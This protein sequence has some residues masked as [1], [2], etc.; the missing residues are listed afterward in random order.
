MVAADGIDS[1]IRRALAPEAVGGR[2]RLRRLAG[3]DP[4]VPRAPAARRARG[5][6][7]DARRRLPLRRPSRSASAAR[8]AGAASTGSPPRPARPG[9][10]RRPPSSRCC[11]AGSP[12]GT[13]P[14][15]ELL[16]ATE[17]EDL[18]PQEVRELRPLPRAYGFRSGPGGVVL[19]G[20]A[21]HAMPH[22]LGQG[23]CLAFED[24]ATLRSL[25]RDAAPGAQLCAAVEAYS[26]LRRPAHH[27][28]GPADPPD[29][30]GGAGPR[31]AG[32]AGPRRRPQPA[33]P[34]HP[35]PR[36]T[37]SPPT[38]PRRTDAGAHG[39]AD[40]RTAA[41]LTARRPPSDEG[42]VRP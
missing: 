31:P 9:R 7:R 15:G 23:A 17:P 22:H 18:V 25:V 3:G 13:P 21:A 20:D 42:R 32:P 37:A 33:A 10:S 30:R 28:R 39:P 5:R 40:W 11:A 16:A 27:Q 35:R 26:R 14:V 4:R 1:P 6:R 8:P 34:A 38:G 24:A 12:A 2:L 19:L 29:V 36:R 41:G